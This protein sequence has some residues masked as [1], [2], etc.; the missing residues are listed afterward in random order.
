M[1]HCCYMAQVSAKK[2]KKSQKSKR[3]IYLTAFAAAALAVLLT[4]GL[5]LATA[6]IV[7]AADSGDPWAGLGA[8][9]VAFYMVGPCLLITMLLCLK[10]SRTPDWPVVGTI[11]VAVLSGAVW[12]YSQ[13]LG[14]TINVA[15]PYAYL[16]VAVGAGALAVFTLV[17]YQ[18]AR[19]RLTAPAAFVAAVVLVGV[20]TLGGGKLLVTILTAVEAPA[21][22][23]AAAQA[24]ADDLRTLHTR[25]SKLG[26]TVY[27]PKVLPRGYKLDSIV[28]SD[29]SVEDTPH[30]LTFNTTAP[31]NAPT[32][33]IYE[34]PVPP[35][36]KPELGDCGP[37]DA[38][39]FPY[40][41][42]PVP[43]TL[44]LTVN[45]T[46]V[47]SYFASYVYPDEYGYYIQ[48]G[49]TAILATTQGGSMPDNDMRALVGSLQPTAIGD[50]P[51][52]LLQLY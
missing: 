36:F 43:C 11:T 40:G 23:R 5:V 6:G 12:L 50:L 48:V 47:Y 31:G 2:P 38:T 4:L 19:A 3:R 7:A 21:N 8:A 13:P 29:G 46:A 25:L 24:R 42:E 41:G 26:F 15:V 51:Q 18:S 10:L 33:I 27:S 52:D 34:L 9:I 45:D 44:L 30:Y 37:Y 32:L 14:E 39:T 16:L 17:V 20:C 49:G 28:P 35:N 1:L 22:R